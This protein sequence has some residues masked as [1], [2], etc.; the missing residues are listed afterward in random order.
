[1]EDSSEG[2]V[3]CSCGKRSGPK[4]DGDH[5]HAGSMDHVRS[6]SPKLDCVS[7]DY[8]PAIDDAGDVSV[9]QSFTDCKI[10]P[11]RELSYVSMESDQPMDDSMP[12]DE[13]VP[14]QSFQSDPFNMEMQEAHKSYLLKKFQSLMEGLT[15]ERNPTLLENIY[16][17]LYITEGGRGEINREHEITQI[18]RA[19]LRKASKCK[20]IKCSEIFESLSKQVKTS[21]EEVK[22]VGIVLTKG[23]AGIGKTVSVQKLIVDWIEGKSIQDVNFIFPLPF[24]E[25]NLM[26]EKDISLV[27]LIKYFFS[28]IEDPG[29]F[30]S[31]QS[32]M[33]IFDGLDECRLP[34]DFRSNP[35]CFDVAESVPLDVLLTNL[36]MKN[37]LPSALVWITTRPAAASK[38]TDSVIVNQVNEI[39]GFNDQQKDAYF[40]KKLDKSLADK[41]IAH[42]KSCRSLYIM[43]HIPIICWIAASVAERK[44]D[45]LGSVVMPRTLTQMYIQFLIFQIKVKGIKYTERDES[46]EESDERNEEMLFK[47]GK[48]AFQQLEEGELIFYKDDL[49]NC[50]IDVTEASVKSGLCTQ[51]FREEGMNIGVSRARVFSFVHL[52]IQE[53]LAALYVFIRRERNMPDRPQSSRLS[54]LFRVPHLHDVHKSAVDLALQSENGDLD[55]FLRFLLGLSLESN[56]ILLR[57]ILPERRSILPETRSQS[58]NAEQTI[59]LVKKMIR[60]QSEREREINLFYCMNELNQHAVVEEIDRRSGTLLVK[61]LIPGEWKTVEFK[62]KTDLDEF[63]LRSYME[64]PEMDKTEVLFP[65]DVLQKLIPSDVFKSSPSAKLYRCNLSEKSCTYLASSLTANSSRLTR[66]QLIMQL[67]DPNKEYESSLTVSSLAGRKSWELSLESCIL[68]EEICHLVSALTSHTTTL[69]GRCLREEEVERLCAILSHQACRLKTLTLWYC[70]LTERSCSYLASAL[71]SSSSHLTLLQLK[72]PDWKEC[73]SSSLSSLTVSSSSGCHSD[74]KRWELRLQDHQLTDEICSCLI[75]ALISHTSTLSGKRLKDQEGERLCSTLGRQDCRL[76]ELTLESFTLSEKSC[77]YL[78]SV[79][80]SQ[81][82]CI[83][84]L[85]LHVHTLYESAAEKLL[86]L[87]NDPR[88]QVCGYFDPSVR[89]LDMSCRRLEE[90]EVRTPSADDPQQTEEIYTD[91]TVA[92]DTHASTSS[93]HGHTANTQLNIQQCTSPAPCESMSLQDEPF[94]MI[95]TTGK[96]VLEVGLTQGADDQ[97]TQ[98]CADTPYTT[99]LHTADMTDD[100]LVKVAKCMGGEWKVVGIGYLGVSV[101]ELDKIQESERNVTMQRIRMLD[102]W[103][104]KNKGKAGLRELRNCLDEDDVP[105]EVR[106]CLEKMLKISCG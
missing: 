24:R 27:D 57:S 77:S 45:G 66:L 8:E 48:L 91:L 18:E 25:L 43:C 2:D 11:S 86:A 6:P 102:L 101:Q 96:H 90:S 97:K 30:T 87:E 5:E 37:L 79:L 50:G 92:A 33:L 34:L 62:F 19:S 70:P 63:D 83:T 81:S 84:Q 22:P 80:T 69:D 38:I 44:S 26:K 98:D 31:K 64:T 53:F 10:S 71:T 46:K 74:C 106:E 41:T 104:M 49:D 1:M 94:K 95:K 105:N 67:K 75:S 100:Q 17:D 73:L 47:L 42:L 40:R 55:L 56:Q 21:S 20:A 51:I 36:I 4:G 23:V 103:R 93:S 14:G 58:Q 13:D 72:D 9:S 76:E 35:E 54:A 32:V 59:Q 61:M 68:T 29:I 39:R 16:T 78:T 60:A 28:G 65:D 89:L 52:S 15:D 88:Y 85:Q 99:E 7:T 3:Q 12:V 82:S